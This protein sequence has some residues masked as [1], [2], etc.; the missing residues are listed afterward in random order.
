MRRNR[1]RGPN[2]AGPGSERAGREDPEGA[3]GRL[4]EGAQPILG[5]PL[6]PNEIQLFRKYLE[7]LRLWNR[8]HRLVGSERPVWIVERL[9][10]DSLLYLPLLPPGAGRV[11]DLGSGA[12]IPGVPLKIVRPDLSLVLAE[13][14]RKRASLLRLV[15]R[16]LALSGVEIIERRL[17]PAG[18][19]PESPFDAVVA[20]CA[21]DPAEVARVAMDL[22]REGGRVIVS[23]PPKPRPVNAAQVAKVMGRHFLVFPAS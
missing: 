7:L 18:W 5:R 22:I 17:G 9:F 23:G 21:G 6:S 12:G 20:R 11:L 10:L 15:V 2:R 3:L 14:R 16:D 1:R 19:Q 8:V 13:A 4:A